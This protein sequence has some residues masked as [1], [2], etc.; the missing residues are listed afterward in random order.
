MSVDLVV[1]DLHG[2]AVP[3]DFLVVDEAF[4]YVIAEGVPHEVALLGGGDGLFE[5]AGKRR[6]AR[7]AALIVGHVEHVGLGRRGEVVALFDALQTGGEHDAEGQIGVAGG[8][9]GTVLDAPGLLPYPL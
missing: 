9:G 2:V 4:E 8:V 6:Y 3:L 5:G 7:L 1:G